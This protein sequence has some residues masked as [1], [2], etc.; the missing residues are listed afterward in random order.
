MGQERR[1][2][3]L[4]SGDGAEKRQGEKGAEGEREDRLT[5]NTGPQLQLSPRQSEASDKAISCQTLSLAPEQMKGS[6]SE[7]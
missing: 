7:P 4:L 2:L 6:L 5:G 3:C 1:G